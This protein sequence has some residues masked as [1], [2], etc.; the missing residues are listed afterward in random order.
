MK[1]T[2]I[3][4]FAFIVSLL[5]IS[6]QLFAQRYNRNNPRIY[7][8]PYDLNLTQKQ[9]EKMDKLE[10]DLEKSLSPLFSRLRTNYL[11]LDELELQRSPDNTKIDKVWE[12]IYTLE[13][14]IERKEIAHEKNIRGLL[15]EDQRAVFDSYNGYG[16]GAGRGY[17]GPGQGGMG[18]GNGAG[19]GSNYLGRGQG[20]YSRGQ[21]VGRLGQGYYGQGRGNGAGYGSNYSGRGQGYYSRGQGVAR[22]TGRFYRGSYRYD[23][24]IRYG[25]GP[26]G[27]GLG[28]YSQGYGRGRWN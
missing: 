6:Q 13:E 21:G 5:F 3:I 8:D 15:T 27:A 4:S 10:L 12:E 25:R 20:Y 22:G 19:Y 23:S 18:N 11:K 1:K 28:R 9:L 17:Y 2:F 14:E 26:C 7:N 16:I 24:R